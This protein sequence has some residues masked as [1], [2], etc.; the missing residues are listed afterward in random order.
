MSSS[1]H[2]VNSPALS[3]GAIIKAVIQEIH[4]IG[5]SLG[6]IAKTREFNKPATRMKG[7]LWSRAGLRR[8]SVCPS[9]LWSLH[10]D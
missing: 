7:S 10:F 1:Y 5:E 4:P 2:Q 6:L 8:D 3:K 9:S